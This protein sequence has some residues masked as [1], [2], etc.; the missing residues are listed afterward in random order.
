MSNTNQFLNNGSLVKYER[1]NSGAGVF[2]PS[3]S[4]ALV[5]ITLVGGGSGG[6]P[7][8]GGNAGETV[9]A[10]VRVTGP[11]NWVV[12][13][14]GAGSVDQFQPPGNGSRTTALQDN[15]VRLIAMG[16]VY[17]AQPAGNV[18]STS[19]ANTLGSSGG[20]AGVSRGSIPGG[21]QQ[22]GTN[23]GAAFSGSGGG[24]GTFGQP[25]GDSLYGPGGNGADIG[26]GGQNGRGPGAGGGG[27]SVSVDGGFETYHPGGNGANGMIIFEEYE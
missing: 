27:G 5:R 4:N 2:N 8:N 11:I 7:I 24:S 14:G 18:N 21:N 12:G 9:I 13:A 3:R 17:L 23:I 19:K 15:G 1:H 10:T 20:T 26:F 22:S 16:G 6:G 25:A